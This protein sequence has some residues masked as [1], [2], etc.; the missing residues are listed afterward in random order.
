[1]AIYTFE[2]ADTEEQVTVHCKMDE[3]DTL[4]EE[5]AAENFHRV[6]VPLMLVDGA[7]GDIYSKS[8]SGWKSMLKRIK[9]SSGRGNTVPNIGVGEV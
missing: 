1:M 7:M 9:G 4:K 8:D 5:M 3:Y 2:N 6:F